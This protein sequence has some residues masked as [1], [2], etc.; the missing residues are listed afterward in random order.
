[1]MWDKNVEEMVHALLPIGAKILG[2]APTRFVQMCDLDGDGEEELAGAYRW[3][4]ETFVTVWKRG[5]EGWYTVQTISS[6]R[7]QITHFHTA[8]V[9]SKKRS[10]LIIG[11]QPVEEK[12]P[13]ETDAK[14]EATE[15]PFPSQH[16]SQS[17]QNT[18]PSRLA[19]YEWTSHGFTDRVRRPLTFHLM[20]VGDLEAIA[21]ADGMSEIVLWQQTDGD[22]LHANVYRWNGEYFIEAND[23]YPV[24]FQKMADYYQTQTKEYPDDPLN[25]YR[26]A[27]AQQ[28]ANQPA[29]AVASME[30]AVKLRP[31]AWKSWEPFVRLIRTELERRATT[32]LFPASV[33][34]AE[35]VK[36]GYIDS[37]GRFIITPSYGYAE[38]FQD[39]GLAIVQV[40][41]RSGLINTLGLFV[42]SPIYQT[43]TPFSEGRAV[44]LDDRGFQVIDEQ[45]N[46]LTAAPYSFIGSFKEGRAVFNQRG[47]QGKYL[48]GY[49]DRSGKEAIPGQYLAA[50]DF[51]DGKAVVEVKEGEHALID[52]SGKVLQSYPYAYVGPM[53]DGLLAFSESLD[54]P[55]GYLD[56]TGK[57]VISPQFSVALPFEEGKAVVNASKDFSENLYGLIDKS[58]SYLI[59]PKYNDIQLLGEGRAA[60]G[61]ALNP[62][63]PYF[64]SIYAIADTN[65]PLLTDFLYTEV[66]EYKE[67]VASVTDGTRTFF[68]DRNGQIVKNLPVVAGRGT[69]TLK[70]GVV[71]ADI[72]QRV[73]YYDRSGNI[74][75][76]QNTI[77]P[78][79]E[80]YRV[81]EHKYAPNKDYL[82]YYPEIK[83][84]ANRAAQEA[85]N[86]RLK[87][88]SQ[89]KPIER[90]VQLDASYFGDFSVSF[91][92]NRLV[93]LELTGYNYPFGAAHGMP[94]K[95]YVPIDLVSGTIYS[96]KALFKPG[97]DYVSVLSEIVAKQIKNDPQYSYVFEGSY[98]GISAD[99]PF[100]VKEDA[101]Y[102]YFAPYEIAPYAAGFPTFRIPFPQISS[103]IDENGEFWKAFH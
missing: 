43:I 27:C 81:I 59:P 42:V 83:G 45:G 51:Q 3:V 11:W 22:A 29:Q 95:Y 75:W 20:E 91:F 86:Q 2:T 84:M 85:V 26:L 49:L 35:G 13:V 92:K 9:T 41:N 23:Q 53:G 71:R 21:G 69:L 39:N 77:I 8:P 34:S 52:R 79:K 19:V 57:V 66:A 62:G 48:Y 16:K 64:G 46:I 99:Q 6:R 38:S 47:E 93:Q 54:G 28:K 65:G 89:I 36:W 78:L 98:K 18:A 60:V 56:E 24:Y 102:L 25:W 17:E 88:L 4:G 10:Q 33:K 31:S 80:P 32:P 30:A 1:M 50:N 72:D 74:I 7:A 14:T 94:T 67:G 58:G 37:A 97:S 44:V 63:K 103:I 100:Y 61:K 68:I 55:K 5:E 82:V 87:E 70:G 90:N 40:K 73:A 76:K 15:S 101:L 12:K 96:L